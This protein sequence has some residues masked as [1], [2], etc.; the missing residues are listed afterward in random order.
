MNKI[1]VNTSVWIAFFK[2]QR[3]SEILNKFL[4]KMDIVL[5]AAGLSTDGSRF[6]LVHTFYSKEVKL[7]VKISSMGAWLNLESRKLV[8]PPLD[9]LSVMNL[10]SK[11]SDFIELP[12]S[13]KG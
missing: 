2:G 11:T 12:S 13:I 10:L 6:K 5:E 3:E 8:K 1:L 7:A 4:D 9:L